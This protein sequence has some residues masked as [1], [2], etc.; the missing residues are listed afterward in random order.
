MG[1]RHPGR[2][3]LCRGQPAQQSVVGGDGRRPPDQRRGVPR[4]AHHR[5]P[6]CP[7]PLR[8][9]QRLAHVRLALQG[10]RVG[11]GPVG[12]DRR[13]RV[14][15]RVE[16][17]AVPA[18]LDDVLPP[19]LRV[20]IT[21]DLREDRDGIRLH[22]PSALHRRSGV[23]S[24]RQQHARRE[25]H[26]RHRDL[27]T[28]APGQRLPLRGEHRERPEGGCGGCVVAVGQQG[29]R[30]HQIRVGDERDKRVRLGWPLDEHPVR[31]EIFQRGQYRPG[32]TGAVVPDTEHPHRCLHRG[33]AVDT[34]VIR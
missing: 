23:R 29:H 12:P 21:G 24:I 33:S 4:T 15:D 7:G 17:V 20:V 2:G 10:A 32:G 30:G 3:D 14:C 5:D 25:V 26:E 22:G 19:T 34:W 16:R 9:P 1:P 6:P 31:L 28:G 8:G 11:L 13:H 18:V 27:L